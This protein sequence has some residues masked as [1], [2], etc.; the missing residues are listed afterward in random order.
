MADDL[1][2]QYEAKGFAVEKESDLSTE[3][4]AIN[5]YDEL[6]L[7]AEPGEDHRLIALLPA[8]AKDYDIQMHHGKRLTCHLLLHDSSVLQRLQTSDPC[9]EVRQ[10]IDV[11][12]FTLYELWNQA[13]VL[14]YEP[15]TIQ[16]E[17]HVHL[18]I[19]GLTEIGER[20]AIHA[21]NVAHYPNYI[22]D[23]SLRTRITIID[24]DAIQKSKQFVSR[25]Q[26]LFDNSYYRM[27]NPLEEKAVVSFHR[28]MYEGRREDFVDVEWEF[29]EADCW[30]SAVRD[31]LALWAEDKTQLLTI[32]LA[33]KDGER[34]I[35]EA[36][37]LPDELTK[38][39]TP[40]YLYTRQNIKSAFRQSIHFFGMDNG[41]YDICQPLVSMAKKVNYIYE[42][43]YHDNI[44]R[45]NGVLRHTVEIDY[46]EAERLWADLPNVRRMSSICNA[47]TIPSKMRSVGIAE[48]EWD[49]F[50]DI[51]EHDIEILSQVEHNRWCMEKL[52]IGFRPCTDDEQ[53]TIASDVKTLKEL[54]KARKIHYDLCA[55]HE[56]RPDGTG[57]SVQI[58]DACLCSCLPLI[59]K[60]SSGEKGGLA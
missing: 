34:N 17:R 50:Y 52:I 42:R 43:C 7:S 31:K 11:Y 58:Y 29:V 49:K 46:G 27:V 32:V 38:H 2:R 20:V 21:A 4:I 5:D 55:Y 28:P 13:I 30:S 16:S 3:G 48:T 41:G 60:E 24:N 33:D 45:W 14:D 57:K 54:Y 59:A 37:Y 23:H 12:P 39:A 25:Y 15:I 10:K 26:T 6:F 22:R 1:V 9:D 47:M 51:A 40:I 19:F 56:L 18:V 53:D 44:E 36:V 8:L 35:A